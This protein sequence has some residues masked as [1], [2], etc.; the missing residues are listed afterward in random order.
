MILISINYFKHELFITG[1]NSVDCEKERVKMKKLFIECLAELF[2]T[3]ILLFFGCMGCYSNPKWI[4]FS[5]GFTIMAIIQCFGHVSGAYFNP[6]VTL[7]AFILEKIELKQLIV[8]SIGQLVGAYLGFLVL[9]ILLPLKDKLCMTLPGE[10]ISIMQCFVIEF[11]IT[12]ILIMVCCAVWDNAHSHNSDSVPIKFGFV[13]TLASLL[14]GTLT[15]A[16]MNPVRSFAPALVFNNWNSHWIYWCSPMLS[17][18]VT[19]C[20]YKH[21]FTTKVIVLNNNYDLE[22]KYVS[23]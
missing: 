2:G 12:M 8:L 16:S 13:I 20:F 23:N 22:Q 18:L 6:A 10:N 17:S 21:F 19:T 9:Y 7:C 5:F 11:L 4:D 15:G 1:T 3:A 14:T